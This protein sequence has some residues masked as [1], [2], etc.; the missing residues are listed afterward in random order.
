[1]RHCCGLNGLVPYYTMFPP[2]LSVRGTGEHES[3]RVGV[4]TLSGGRGNYHPCGKIAGACLQSGWIAIRV[5][6]AIAAAKLAQGPR[7]P[8]VIA[9][10]NGTSLPMCGPAGPGPPSSGDTTRRVLGVGP[11]AFSTLRDICRI[12]N[13]LLGAVLHP[14]RGHSSRRHAWHSAR[15][16]DPE[17]R[18]PICRTRCPAPTRRSHSQPSGTGGSAG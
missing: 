18:R 7:L 16:S 6:G 10:R 8:K 5:A 14:H 2:P 9:P 15:P 4:L 13:Y 11:T 1:M 17:K 3:W 12:R